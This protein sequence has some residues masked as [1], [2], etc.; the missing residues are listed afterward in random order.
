MSDRTLGLLSNARVS[1]CA[2]IKHLLLFLLEQDRSWPLFLFPEHLAVVF[3]LH[4]Q[5]GN[6]VTMVTRPKPLTPTVLNHLYQTMQ[7]QQSLLHLA[8]QCWIP[9]TQPPKDPALCW[10][11]EYAWSKI[12]K[13]K[14]FQ[15]LVRGSYTHFSQ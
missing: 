6:P 15:V 4:D 12:N 9:T 3:H 8:R 2:L 1:L 13:Q 5:Q 14:Q 10:R 11:T 7:G